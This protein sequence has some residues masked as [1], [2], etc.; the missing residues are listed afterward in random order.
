MYQYWDCAIQW[1]IKFFLI[2]LKYYQVI[3]DE[4]N[5]KQMNVVTQVQYNCINVSWTKKNT[6]LSETCGVILS[7][8][9]LSNLRQLIKNKWK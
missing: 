6:G 7:K 3:F 5:I 4:I 8:W 2:N 9:S 1:L